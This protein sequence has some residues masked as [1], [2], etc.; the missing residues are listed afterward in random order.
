M[1]WNSAAFRPAAMISS[2]LRMNTS[3]SMNSLA[4][5]VNISRPL[6]M[7]S[8]KLAAVQGSTCLESSL[9]EILLEKPSSRRSNTAIE[10]NSRPMPTMCTIST[11]G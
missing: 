3:L 7:M 6:G 8:R 9:T 1:V 11:V 4:C 5:A 2:I 10:P